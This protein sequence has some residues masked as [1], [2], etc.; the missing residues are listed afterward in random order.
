MR[1]FANRNPGELPRHVHEDLI[2]EVWRTRIVL[3]EYW[4]ENVWNE[5]RYDVELF[6][7]FS[8]L[9]PL[10]LASMSDAEVVSRLNGLREAEEIVSGK[11]PSR[12]FRGV[13]GFNENVQET[14]FAQLR[15]YRNA[16]AAFAPVLALVAPS[17]QPAKLWEWWWSM[18]DEDALSQWSLL[19]RIAVLHQPSSAVIERFF[20][21]YKGMTSAQQCQ[22]DEETS[23][24]RALTRYNKGKVGL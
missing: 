3:A 23:Y 4:K 7:G 8:V 11:S 19:A 24:L 20:S 1:A 6:R 17:D 5:M 15:Q 18:R 21:V 10:Q 22:E 14:L 2:G 13:K 9:D 16:A 12:R